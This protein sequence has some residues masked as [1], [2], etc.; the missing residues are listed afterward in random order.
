[1][2]GNDELETWIRKGL[3]GERERAYGLPFLG[4]NNFLVDRLEPLENPLPAYWFER[5]D[6]E[7]QEGLRDN[8]TRLTI[9]IDRKE[10]SRTQSSL[11]EPSKERIVEVPPK[12]WVEVIYSSGRISNQ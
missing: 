5:I 12:A 9:T 6:A 4:D 1:V 10:M 2:D 8:V 11:F 7:D 3:L